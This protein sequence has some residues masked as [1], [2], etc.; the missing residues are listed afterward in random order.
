MLNPWALFGGLLILIATAFGGAHVGKKLEREAWQAERLQLVAKQSAD[1]AKKAREYADDIADQR[2]KERKAAQSYETA[3]DS[4][5]KAYRVRIA[6][7][8]RRGGLRI[9]VPKS[10]C[11]GPAKAGEAAG[12]QLADEEATT[13]VRLPGDVERNL[14]A[15]AASADKV[16]AQCQAL[17]DW[18]IDNGLYGPTE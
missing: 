5:D 3:L 16:V 2:T 15:L 6:D 12:P 8:D 4:L 11:A 18:V 1:T 7:S 14:F 10:Q 17:Q 13:L 9:A